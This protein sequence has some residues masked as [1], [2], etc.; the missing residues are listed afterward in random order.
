MSPGSSRPRRYAT[1]RVRLH[2]VGQRA[3]GAGQRAGLLPVVLPAALC[4]VGQGDYRNNEEGVGGEGGSGE[5]RFAL[6]ESPLGLCLRAAGGWA[7]HERSPHAE[8]GYFVKRGL[9]ANSPTI[10]D[11]QNLIWDKA[12]RWGVYK[13][14]PCVDSPPQP[15][16]SLTHPSAQ[17]EL[18]RPGDALG[19]GRLPRRHMDAARRLLHGHGELE[20][21]QRRLRAPR[22]RHV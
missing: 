7:D 11:T 12:K 19:C 2:F 5:G 9:L 4:S 22:R 17:G 14:D 16:L 6:G 18:D 21:A 3:E 15:S 1:S 20:V 10:T 13:D 8:N